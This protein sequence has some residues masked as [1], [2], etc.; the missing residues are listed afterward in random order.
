MPLNVAI[1]RSLPHD[2][3]LVFP[4][5]L[6][7]R[8]SL[9]TWLDS[10]IA[11][12]AAR[13]L[14]PNLAAAHFFGSDRLLCL[15]TTPVW[16]IRCHSFV[17]PRQSAS[18]RSGGSPRCCVPEFPPRLH[19][20]HLLPPYSSFCRPAAPNVPPPPPSRYFA[21]SACPHAHGSPRRS[22]SL[23]LYLTEPSGPCPTPKPSLFRLGTAIL[24]CSLYLALATVILLS[25]LA[26]LDPTFVILIGASTSSSIALPLSL[27]L[28][29][30]FCLFTNSLLAV[31]INTGLVT[32]A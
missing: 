19:N 13:T 8:I 14:P 28:I 9:P 6:P 1:G 32:V 3:W 4:A 30:S 20:Y 25:R 12:A 22:L 21:S 7:W 11:L 27:P 2:I 10:S 31:I 17:T 5:T 24:R 15:E 18:P 16:R 26:S 23:S 29:L